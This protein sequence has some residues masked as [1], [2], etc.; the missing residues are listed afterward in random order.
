MPNGCNKSLFFFDVWWYQA[1]FLLWSKLYRK[2]MSAPQEWC[3]WR[4]RDKRKRHL[5]NWAKL[6]VRRL[7]VSN[8]SAVAF[9]EKMLTFLLKSYIIITWLE[10]IFSGV[11]QRNCKFWARTTMFL[12]IF[13]QTL[14]RDDTYHILKDLVLG[15]GK[16]L[17]VISKNC[18]SFTPF[19]V[20]YSMGNY[21]AKRGRVVPLLQSRNLFD[22]WQLISQILNSFAKISESK[23]IFLFRDLFATLRD[24]LFK[25][26][27]GFNAKQL[28]FR[29]QFIEYFETVW[30]AVTNVRYW[31]KKSVTGF[32]DVTQKKWVKL[33]ACVTHLVVKLWAIVLML[34]WKQM[35]CC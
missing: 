1:A 18:K 7:S 30:F 11:A 20:A 17:R 13:F 31:L 12:A 19:S 28:S 5:L 27:M 24:D 10:I 34:I 35:F 9:A 8:S 23:I 15:A 33:W 25:K 2:Y 32:A 4:F 6:L 14:S 26:T 22:S 21:S 3:L 16:N 29:K